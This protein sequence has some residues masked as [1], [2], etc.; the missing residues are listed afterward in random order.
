M[1]SNGPTTGSATVTVLGS[2]MDAHVDS[3]ITSADCQDGIARSDMEIG[4][5]WWHLR[6]QWRRMV[7]EFGEHGAREW[8]ILAPSSSRMDIRTGKQQQCCEEQ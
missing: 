6:Q 7:T 1:A 2:G 5:A 3:D 4:S 8:T